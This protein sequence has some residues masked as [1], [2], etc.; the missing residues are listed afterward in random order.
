MNGIKSSVIIFCLL[1]SINSCNE[2]SLTTLATVLTSDASDVTLTSA[3]VGGDVSNDGGATV[4]ERGVVLGTSRTQPV[5]YQTIADQFNGTGGFIINLSNLIPNTT[6][7]VRAYAVNEIGTSY[8]NEIVFTTTVGLATVTTSMAFST[9][10]YSTKVSGEVTLENGSDVT[11]RGIVYHTNT[12]PTLQNTKVSSG[13]G[14]GVFT[15]DIP[16][17]QPNTTYFVKAFAT[18]AAGTAYGNEI[19]FTTKSLIPSSGLVAWYPFNGNANDESGNENHGTVF[20]ATLTTD[21]FSNSDRAYNFD[22]SSNYITAPYSSSLGVQN[23]IT[24][25]AWIYMDGGGCN[26]RILEINS[27]FSSCGGY[28]FGTNGTSNENR[29][30]HTANL[31]DCINEVGPTASPE[32]HA[33]SW[34]HVAYTVDGLTGKGN[35]YFNGE[36][37][38]AY[39]GT[40]FSSIN[41]NNNPLTIGNINPGRCDW[42]GGKI[43]DVAIFDRVLTSSEILK[44]YLAE[45][46]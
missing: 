20:G 22:G 1:I 38:Y 26:P 6:Y 8:G 3:I 13:N 44:I 28:S 16:D 19:N 41:Y 2:E 45:G 27:V 42:W 33:L 35:L 32:L 11:E 23:Q 40:T 37:V 12:N 46:F 9:K 7:F 31:G 21:K 17:L 10:V 24:V 43:D 25:A 39:A 30:F 36:M 34:Q 18:N 14:V 29:T 4:T 5:P 15:I